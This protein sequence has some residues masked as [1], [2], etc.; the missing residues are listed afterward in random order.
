MNAAGK[1]TQQLWD[2]AHPIFESIVESDFAHELANGTLSLD[3]FSHFLSQDMLYL[4]RDAEALGVVAS[5]CDSAD[6]K[7]FFIKM[8]NDGIAVE[9][10]LH[11]E[12]L[13]KF[14]ITP[15]SKSSPAFAAYIN[16]LLEC[17]CHKDLSLAMVA[18]LPCFWIY[19]E[20]GATIIS[21]SKQN[22]PYQLFI[23]LY[24]G[25]EYDEYTQQFIQIV[26]ENLT[27]YNIEKAVELFKISATH[28][29]NI[30]K[31]SYALGQ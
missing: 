14:N 3:S 27:T 1:N 18:L 26:E 11:N 6:H 4:K 13:P 21:R 9:Q 25:A 10:S 7:A 23:D 15:A 16:H 31:E 20:V 24:A 30:W 17:S 2:A 22:N 19:G 29:L 8:Q 28:E 12:L 5:R